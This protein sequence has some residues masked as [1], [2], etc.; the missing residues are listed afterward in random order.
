MKLVLLIL[1]PVLQTLP[2]NSDQT[3]IQLTTIKNPI[4]PIQLGKAKI[5]Y[6]KHTFLHYIDLRP[7]VIQLENVEKYFYRLRKILLYRKNQIIL[8][9]IKG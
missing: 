8:F 2:V 7:I 5:I 1:L 6:N 3:D 9:L 4:L